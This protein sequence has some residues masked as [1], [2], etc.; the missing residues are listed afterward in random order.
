MRVIQAALAVLVA[1]LCYGT[2]A[3]LFRKRDRVRKHL[4]SAKR[5]R[6]HDEL[7]LTNL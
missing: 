3:K 7:R 6:P 5:T 4:A 2:F 1:L